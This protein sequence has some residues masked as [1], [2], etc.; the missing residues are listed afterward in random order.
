M[1]ITCGNTKVPSYERTKVTLTF[2][3]TSVVVIH[4]TFIRAEV[5]GTKQGKIYIRVT[6]VRTFTF[7]KSVRISS[8]RSA[9][10]N[11]Y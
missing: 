5:I 11:L 4:L 7:V 3:D 8:A 9:K 6:F 2:M 10:S 1:V